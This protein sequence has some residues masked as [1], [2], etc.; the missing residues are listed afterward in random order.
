MKILRHRTSSLNHQRGIAIFL[1]AFLLLPITLLLLSLGFD[2][3]R[4]FSQS[5]SAQTALDQAVKYGA[6]FLPNAEAARERAEGYLR[7][8]AGERWK[9]R[10]AV[11]GSRVEMSAKLSSPLMF[12]SFFGSDLSLD[13]SVYSAAKIAPRDLLVALIV[14][15]ENAPAYGDEP[16]GS[17]LEWPAAQ[18][19]TSGLTI[20]DNGKPLD[21]R[22]LTQQCFNPAFS[23][24]KELA[25]KVYEV[26]S[27][28]PINSVGLGYAPGALNVY[29]RLRLPTEG[30]ARIYQEQSFDKGEADFPFLTG[31]QFSSAEWCAAAA[32]QE[33][34]TLAYNFPD[35]NISL[36][37]YVRNK[38]SERLS[39][40][41]NPTDFTIN[42]GELASLAAREAI[43]SL[44]VSASS[45][46]NFKMVVGEMIS[47]LLTASYRLDRGALKE[48]PRKV[49]YLL[50]AHYPRIGQANFF[51]PAFSGEF[52]SYLL[53]LNHSLKDAGVSINLIFAIAPF[54]QQGVYQSD[55]RFAETA[56]RTRQEYLNGLGS[57]SQ[58]IDFQFVSADSLDELK[59]T[60]ISKLPTIGEK[61]VLSR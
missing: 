28:N 52:I 53:S 30:G 23:T 5:S 46:P 7:S 37:R 32:E 47:E 18:V 31:A 8:L 44:P 13:L 2:L 29:S 40:L 38:L 10:S 20:L 57:A 16:W 58:N 54:N 61:V 33:K 19:F 17:S 56:A 51:D 21:P 4:Y 60:L 9:V 34:F 24:I 59:R 11:D 22:W 15:N 36:R 50:T 45:E 12:A 42:Q 35:E 25:V 1:F 49:G 39:P 26:L 14:S 6:A 43:W 48:A 55:A 27:S 3:T 41:V